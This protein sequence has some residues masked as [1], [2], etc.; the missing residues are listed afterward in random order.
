MLVPF[1]VH[2]CMG[3]SQKI[4]QT[5]IFV[6]SFGGPIGGNLFSRFDVMCASVATLL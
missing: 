2:V 1:V 3:E 6:V 4:G 5:T